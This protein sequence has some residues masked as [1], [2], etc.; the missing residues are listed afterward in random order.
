MRNDDFEELLRRIKLPMGILLDD[1]TTFRI[2][3]PLFSQLGRKAIR[4]LTNFEKFLVLSDGCLNVVGGVLFYGNTDLQVTI[5]PEHRGN[6][7]MS[8]IHKN[9]IL[10]SE[11][12]E[13]Q[14]VS[15]EL[16]EI[17]TMDDFLLRIHMLNYIDVP[18]KNMIEVY[19]HLKW[20]RLPE[21]VT[22]DENRFVREFSRKQ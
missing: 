8:T 14:R 9:G 18:A 15:L 1:E 3:E 17:K 11:C 7:Y 16:H 2:E 10:A 22:Y 13:G 20:L 6:H 4:E 5:L 19:K 21:L 12:Y